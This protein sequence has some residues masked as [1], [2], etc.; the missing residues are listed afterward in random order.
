M[1]SDEP[2]YEEL[3]EENYEL[4]EEKRALSSRMQALETDLAEHAGAG[5]ESERRA[6]EIGRLEKDL[7]DANT[8]LRA[9]KRQIEKQ[10]T[11]GDMRQREH[12]RLETALRDKEERYYEM[13][14]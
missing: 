2:T 11:E 5:R 4:H 7:A 8:D 10:K 6:S 3:L 13:Y 14:S 1:T 12:E 9:C